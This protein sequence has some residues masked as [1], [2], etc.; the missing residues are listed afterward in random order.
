MTKYLLKAIIYTVY[1]LPFVLS[2]QSDPPLLASLSKLPAEERARLVNQYG[3]M[4]GD[5]SER[6]KS[7]SV[8][9]KNS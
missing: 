6:P 1:L 7:D 2:A 8:N 5:N 4:S 3:L 9:L